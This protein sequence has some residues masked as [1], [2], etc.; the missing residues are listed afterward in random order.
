MWMSKTPEHFYDYLQ[1]FC[2]FI[3]K[4]FN[5]NWPLQVRTTE[6]K[7]GRKYLKVITNRS[8]LRSIHSFIELDSGDVYKAASWRSPAKHV[9]GTIITDDTRKYGVNAYL[10]LIHI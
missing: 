5:D 9:R 6:I 8:G 4:E 3:E 10:S 7:E 1:K 2:S